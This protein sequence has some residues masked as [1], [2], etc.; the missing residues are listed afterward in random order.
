M[1]F[2]CL[3]VRPKKCIQTRQNI[4]Q[5]HC[6]ITKQRHI[7]FTIPFLLHVHSVMSNQMSALLFFL[8]WLNAAFTCCIRR[9]HI[10]QIS[11]CGALS[12]CMQKGK[13]K[14]RAKYIETVMFLWSIVWNELILICR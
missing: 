7:L 8:L 3:I 11:G 14:N 5:M 12:C 1:Y 10:S 4:Q 6:I 13:E 9:V 2:K